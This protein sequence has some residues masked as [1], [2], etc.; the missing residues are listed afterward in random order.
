MARVHVDPD[1]YEVRDGRLLPRG[2]LPTPRF[3]GSTPRMS[4]KE[5]LQAVKSFAAVLGWLCYH[6]LW[7]QG[8]SPGFP[9]LTMIRGGRVIFVELKSP[10]GKLTVHQA[11]WLL[12]LAEAG[13][14]VHVW[15]PDD[16][17]VRIPE[18]LR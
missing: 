6:T 13:A 17:D 11:R 3:P 9:D 12:G 15:R 4:E 5:L 18:V 7:A 16:L 14:E 2:P 1:Q 8:S 10:T